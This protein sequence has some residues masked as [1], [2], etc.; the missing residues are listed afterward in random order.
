MSN[1]VGDR[2][3]ELQAR[4]EALVLE[5]EVVRAEEE[6]ARLLRIEFG[7]R[8]SERNRRRGEISREVA[9]LEREIAVTRAAGAS[10]SD[11]SDRAVVRWLELVER[12]DTNAIRRDL[13]AAMRRVEAIREGDYLIYEVQVRGA[14]VRVVANKVGKIFTVTPM[15]GRKE[16]GP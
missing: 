16:T 15:D 7:E 10:L 12:I 6:A 4:H 1:D 13:V 5:S 11:V 9:Q 2:I 14:Q 8:Q 3:R